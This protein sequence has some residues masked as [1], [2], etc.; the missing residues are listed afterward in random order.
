VRAAADGLGEIRERGGVADLLHS[1]HIGVQGRSISAA[2]RLSMG[3]RPSGF[4]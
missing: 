2:I 1:E 3:G 4:G